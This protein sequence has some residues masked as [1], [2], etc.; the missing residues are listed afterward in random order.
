M[1]MD[2][3]YLI[4][5]WYTPKSKDARQATREEV[6]KKIKAEQTKHENH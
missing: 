2:P 1:A 6:E 3:E 4:I 5:V